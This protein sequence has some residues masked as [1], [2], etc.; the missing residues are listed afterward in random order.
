[1]EECEGGKWKRQPAPQKHL[2]L[3]RFCD[4]V[5][6]GEKT[7][8]VRLPLLN[9]LWREMKERVKEGVGGGGSPQA[10]P[11]QSSD[12]RT[13]AH[14]TTSTATGSTS[15]ST[16]TAPTTTSS[17]QEEKNDGESNYLWAENQKTA[18]GG[19]C[20][21]LLVVT[22][23][24]LATWAILSFITDNTTLSFSTQMLTSSVDSLTTN[25][26][27][28]A[29]PSS[30]ISAALG[31]SLRPTTGIQIRVF[32]QS[33][34]GCAAPAPFV[35]QGTPSARFPFNGSSSPLF[36]VASGEEAQWVLD[37]PTA[38]AGTPCGGA[39]G[40]L[41]LFTLSCL[42]CKLSASSFVS[43]YLPFTCQSALVE[44]VS[45][46]AFGV[47]SAVGVAMGVP[48]GSPNGTYL[49]TFSIPFTASLATLEDKREQSLSQGLFF[50]SS[51]LSGPKSIFFG[52]K[53]LLGETSATT[54]KPSRDNA[55]G[56]ILPLANRVV[57]SVG[58]G[59]VPSYSSTVLSSKTTSQAL[60]GQLIGL[61]GILAV[62]K[63]FF[64]VVRVS[65]V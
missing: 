42:S 63:G 29:P 5:S 46:D 24:T 28:W 4:F 20:T 39:K 14:T 1:M 21:F 31:S 33:A 22:L 2:G 62:F 58:L 30:R 13:N 3:F 64:M 8:R 23:S 10:S 51:A 16:P 45:V 55:E 59:L 50:K 9:D 56:G 47:V 27:G 35:T 17:G 19:L 38:A 65:A 11:S 34:N 32:G 18:F 15:L 61:L 36:S 43:L 6:N 41:S 48:A 53:L 60:V 7:T 40:G 57:L 49:A 52:L 25:S 12:E 37:L 26:S 44:I 54:F